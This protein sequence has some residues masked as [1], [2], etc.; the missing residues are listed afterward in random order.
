MRAL[1]AIEE[2]F[3][4]ALFALGGA[5]VGVGVGD[6]GGSAVGTDVH[7][8]EPG[9]D[10]GKGGGGEDVAVVLGD[11]EGERHADGGAG[12]DAE[13]YRSGL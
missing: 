10:G 2:V 13:V 12:G 7:A 4:L 3:L 1:G 11:G 9:D 6:F 5:G 8:V